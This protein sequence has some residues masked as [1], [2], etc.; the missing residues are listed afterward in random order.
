MWSFLEDQMNEITA[1][2]IRLE[3]ELQAVTEQLD[4]ARQQNEAETKLND[5]L[6]FH[7]DVDQVLVQDIEAA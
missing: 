6:H 4:T 1:G 2:R 3:Q 5:L 7:V